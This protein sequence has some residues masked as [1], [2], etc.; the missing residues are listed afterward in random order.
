MF[1][2]AFLLRKVLL[3]PTVSHDFSSD[4]LVKFV[5]FKIVDRKSLYC[6]QLLSVVVEPGHIV[7]ENPNSWVTNCDDTG[8]NVYNRSKCAEIKL[9]EFREVAIIRSEPIS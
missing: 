5:I 3:Q 8:S 4:V 7:G 9:F 2:T 1:Y 6:L